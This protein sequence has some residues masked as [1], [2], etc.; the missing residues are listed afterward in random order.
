MGKSGVCLTY[1]IFVPQNL[2]ASVR[3]LTGNDVPIIDFLWLMVLVEIPLSWIQNVRHFTI[4]NVIANFL[5]LYGLL[6]CLGFAANNLIES[7]TTEDQLEDN[8]D[9]DTKEDQN[10]VLDID[11]EIIALGPFQNIIKKMSE[12]RPFGPGWFLFIGTSVSSQ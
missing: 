1:L 5:I 3:I 9:N 6:T 10:D 12:L 8:A 2:Q 11:T 4:T 7:S